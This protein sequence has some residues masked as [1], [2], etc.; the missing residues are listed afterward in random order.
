M[1][2]ISKIEREMLIVMRKKI[3][4]NFRNRVFR[5]AR[6]DPGHMSVEAVIENSH[7]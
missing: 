4:K 2:G 3:K 1:F 7:S 5:K 6:G